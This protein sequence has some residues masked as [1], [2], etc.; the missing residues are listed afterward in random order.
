MKNIIPRVL[1]ILAVIVVFVI[2]IWFLIPPESNP[3]FFRV[4][5]NCED[6]LEQIGSA[7]ALYSEKNGKW[8]AQLTDL[9][10]TYLKD[11][12]VI[13]CPLTN[14]QYGYAQPKPDAPSDTTIITCTQHNKDLKLKIGVILYK[15]GLVTRK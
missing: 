11:S 10:P 2:F 1:L 8:P 6:N 13:N 9:I 4:F 3:R 12:K 5:T 7:T 14:T 15:S